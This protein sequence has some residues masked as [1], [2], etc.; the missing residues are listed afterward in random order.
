MSSS[1][2]PPASKPVAFT[3]APRQ[4]PPSAIQYLVLPDIAYPSASRRLNE[5]GLVVVAVFMDTEGLPQQVQI[6]QSSG[7]DRLDQAALV[8]VRRARFR[9]YTDNGQALAGWARIPIP[10]ELEH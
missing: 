3:A 9:P 2:T 10:F 8:G 6:A 7:Y 4:I 5:Q 1:F